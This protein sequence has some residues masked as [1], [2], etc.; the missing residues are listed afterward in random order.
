METDFAKVCCKNCK[1]FEERS[2]FC[3]KNPPQVLNVFKKDLDE[4]VIASIFPVIKLSEVD[5][6]S[7]HE[8]RLI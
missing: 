1:H 3:R 2:R 8:F 4:M 5:Y 6:C 7:Y